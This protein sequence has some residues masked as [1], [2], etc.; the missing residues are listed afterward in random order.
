[1]T[2]GL[3]ERAKALR[4]P[5]FAG[6]AEAARFAHDKITAIL[7]SDALAL[8]GGRRYGNLTRGSRAFRSSLNLLRSPRDDMFQ[9]L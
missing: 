1:M 7:L 3:S 9:K 4:L 6:E 2:R 8:G 5:A